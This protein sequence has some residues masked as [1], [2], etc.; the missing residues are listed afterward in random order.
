MSDKI[1]NTE[2]ATS[3]SECGCGCKGTKHNSIYEE[4]KQEQN[5][6]KN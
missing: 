5:S 3:N 6:K 2:K 1:K 4:N